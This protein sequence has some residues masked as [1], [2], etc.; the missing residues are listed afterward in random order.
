MTGLYVDFFNSGN[1]TGTAGNSYGQ[2]N[3]PLPRAMTTGEKVIIVPTAQRW[4][5]AEV[6]HPTSGSIFAYTAHCLINTSVMFFRFSAIYF[7]EN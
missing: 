6:S 3:K 5:V 1:L 2:T 4:G 7:K